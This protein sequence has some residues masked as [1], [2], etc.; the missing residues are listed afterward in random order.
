MVPPDASGEPVARSGH[1]DMRAQAE[2]A[3]ALR[4]ETPKQFGQI[5]Q[6]HLWW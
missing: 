1:L 6:V 4:T 3:S 5:A 2:I